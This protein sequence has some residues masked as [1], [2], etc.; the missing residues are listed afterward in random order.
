MN[1]DSRGENRAHARVAPDYFGA[2]VSNV[3]SPTPLATDWEFR[4]CPLVSGRWPR[5]PRARAAARSC[6]RRSGRHGPRLLGRGV[7]LGLRSSASR[8]LTSELGSA[9]RRAPAEETQLS[10][11]CPR[12]ARATICSPVMGTRFGRAVLPEVRMSSA[13]S[14]G[15]GPCHVPQRDS[16]AE[17]Q[18]SLRVGISS[19]RATSSATASPSTG[20]MSVL[21]RISFSAIAASPAGAD[22]LNGMHTAWQATESVMTAVSG[23]RD[24]RSATR[25]PRSMPARS[26]RATLASIRRT[27]SSKQIASCPGARIAGASGCSAAS[28]ASAL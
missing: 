1:T 15:P 7:A 27:S 5:T 2:T 18:A 12:S 16:P 26:S 28:R 22:E 25:S 9:P 24:E 23:P 14:E 13:T 10:L 11:L 20:T 8:R 17:S 6:A 19:L 4:E 21:A 3:A